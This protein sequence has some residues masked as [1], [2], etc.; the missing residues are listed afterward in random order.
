[1]NG[2]RVVQVEDGAVWSAVKVA[3]AN[4]VPPAI[5]HL[6]PAENPSAET[7]TRGQILHADRTRVWQEAGK[8]RVVVHNRVDFDKVP[9]IGLVATI[10]YDVANAR[11]QVEAPRAQPRA[12]SR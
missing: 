6:L 12:R 4:G 1:M 2:Q 11:A 9:D 5:Y 10:K 7:P 8:G 3:K